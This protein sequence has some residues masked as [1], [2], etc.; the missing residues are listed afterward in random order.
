MVLGVNS[1]TGAQEKTDMKTLLFKLLYGYFQN[2]A[3]NQ[4]LDLP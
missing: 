3:F 4:S 1:L 2:K